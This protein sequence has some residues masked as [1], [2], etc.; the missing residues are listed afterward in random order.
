MEKFE[1]WQ[2]K[3]DGKW[4]FHLIAPNGEIIAH[5]QG[6]SSKDNC[7]NGIKSVKFY[8]PFAIIYEK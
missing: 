3:N 8:A 5:S 1:F 7:M 6:Y 4:Y 2:S